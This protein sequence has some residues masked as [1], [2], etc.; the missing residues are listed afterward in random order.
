M[1]N[2]IKRKKKI[3]KKKNKKKEKEKKGA[4]VHP[5]V[6]F[7]LFQKGGLKTAL[8]YVRQEDLTPEQPSVTPAT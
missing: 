1:T 2:Q 5:I 8:H 7:Y 4:N 3:R 6:E